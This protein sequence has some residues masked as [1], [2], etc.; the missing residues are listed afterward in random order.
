[1]IVSIHL[2]LPK[3]IFKLTLRYHTFEKVP[4]D[5]YLISSLYLNSKN[6]SIVHKY[7]DEISGKGS[8]NQHFKKIFEE[9]KDLNENQLKSIIKDSLYPV[10]KI[11]EYDFS[12]IPML[13]ISDFKGHI[14]NGNLIDDNHFPLQLIEEG[15]TYISHR[16]DVINTKVEKDRFDVNLSDSSIEIKIGQNYHQI[17]NNDFITIIAKDDINVNDYKGTIHNSLTGNNWI[18]LSKSNYNNIM[19]VSD[20][21]YDNGDH[22][23]IYSDYAKR[24][25]IA[26]NWGLYWVKEEIYRYQDNKNAEI[27][28]RIIDELMNTGRINEFKTKSLLDIMKR[29]NRDKQQ[30]TINYILNRKDSKDIALVGLLLID[31]GY[32]KGW[33]IE[34]LKSFYKYYNNSVQLAKLYQ[35]N[36]ELGYTTDDL[37]KVYNVN[38]LLLSSNHKETVEQY[39]SDCDS[40]KKSMAEK[41]GEISLSGIREK[42]GRM[43]LDDDTKKFRKQLNVIMA[44]YE[45][46]INE[47]NLAQLKV[48]EKQINEFYELFLKVSSKWSDFQNKHKL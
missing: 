40:L 38:K 24:S 30:M 45:K 41:V 37:I 33:N 28:E 12:Y 9:I 35:I 48:M 7:I 20:F 11:N 25:S 26:S 13:N 6:E 2:N 29:I 16:Y 3:T 43:I 19:N 36:N 23:A 39:Y 15:G 4:F 22:I 10:E 44:H 27:C 21:Y 18:Q 47:K 32:E 34:S 17:S 14:T 31:K 46:N 42:I 1:M 5:K 8:L